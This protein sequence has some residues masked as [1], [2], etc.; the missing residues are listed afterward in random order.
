[1]INISWGA[2]FDPNT[3]PSQDGLNYCHLTSEDR[4]TNKKNVWM[5]W[6]RVKN[7]VKFRCRNICSAEGKMCSDTQ[8]L[9]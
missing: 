9:F 1:M 3:E 8:Q 6:Q 5:Y 2:S 4:K 7:S